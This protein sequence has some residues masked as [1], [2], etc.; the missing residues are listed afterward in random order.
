MR[1]LKPG[2]DPSPKHT[3]LSPSSEE[4]PVEDNVRIHRNPSTGKGGRHLWVIFA[5]LAFTL[6][7][8]NAFAENAFSIY[9]GATVTDSDTVTVTDILSSPPVSISKEVDFDVGVEFGL[10]YTYWWRVFGL[11]LD[12]SF[13]TVDPHQTELVSYDVLPL[14]LYIMARWPLQRGPRFPQGRFHPYIGIGPTWAVYEFQVNDI[15]LP[16]GGGDGDGTDTT[17]SGLLGFNWQLTRRHAF[18]LEIKHTQIDVASNDSHSYWD[19]PAKLQIEGKLS[20]THFLV[21]YTFKF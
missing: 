18:F 2:S 9:A 8:K 19:I 1:P 14:S 21:G 20:T 12:M 5:L 10:R 4:G 11:A 17:I 15:S 3:V 16:Y 7:A 13:F 6:S